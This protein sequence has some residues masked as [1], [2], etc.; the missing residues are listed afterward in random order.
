M[1][2]NSCDTT[3][4]DCYSFYIHTTLSMVEDFHTINLEWSLYVCESMAVCGGDEL[5]L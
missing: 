5:Q 4:R 2:V 3:L 1:C